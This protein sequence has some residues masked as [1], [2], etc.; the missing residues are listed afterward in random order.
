M[1][2]MKQMDV[3][4]GHAVINN[5]TSYTDFVTTMYNTVQTAMDNLLSTWNGK[6]KDQFD[7]TWSEYTTSVNNLKQH[8]D[9]LKTNLQFEVR[10]VEET[11]NS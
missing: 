10:Q 1:A 6:S 4:A 7:A 11:F 2:D 9:T 8:L 3:E 5:F